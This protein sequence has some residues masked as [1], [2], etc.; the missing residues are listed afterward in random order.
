[1]DST[2]RPDPNKDSNDPMISEYWLL[3]EDVQD[4]IRKAGYNAEEVEGI[5]IDIHDI[6]QAAD[7]IRDEIAPRIVAADPEDL[8]DLLK[9][10]AAEVDHIRWHC[11][12]ASAYL[13]DAQSQ[14]SGG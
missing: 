6:L 14:L 7:R 11:D 1:M 3:G 13:A 5:A 4:K 9:D 2:T 12:S 8:R 10:F